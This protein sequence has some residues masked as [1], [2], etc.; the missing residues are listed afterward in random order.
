[1]QTLVQTDGQTIAMMERLPYF[2]GLQ[3]FDLLR[4][5]RGCCQL[6]AVEGER[7]CDKGRVVDFVSI[8]ISGQ[9][10][11]SLQLPDGVEKVLAFAGRGDSFGEAAA[12]MGAE[13]PVNVVAMSH[14]HILAVERGVLLE[15]MASN[16][17]LA[18]RVIRTVSQRLLDMVRDTETCHIRSSVDRVICYLKHQVVSDAGNAI[19]F[20]FPAQK[21]EIAAN[22]SMTPETF[23]RALHS[24][25]RKGAIHMS[26][27]RVRILDHTWL[28]A[29]TQVES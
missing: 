3:R 2:E 24:L 21:K 29:P 11:I 1:M 14:S 19:E 12:I 15:E 17:R 16:P 23:S 4:L 25:A 27:R 9:L 5:T 10:K 13:N 7:L 8:V 18:L 22:L 20:E 26:G 6:M 28:H